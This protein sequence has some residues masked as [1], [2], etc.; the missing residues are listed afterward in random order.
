MMSD[1]ACFC[2]C[3]FSFDG[4]AAACP[5]CGE[6]ASVTASLVRGDAGPSQSAVPV[7]VVSGIGHNRQLPRAGTERVLRA[8]F[9]AAVS[10][11]SADRYPPVPG[12]GDRAH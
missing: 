7:P 12:T 11:R 10:P 9:I 8:L 4:G 2:G 3:R 5:S 6:I 1:V